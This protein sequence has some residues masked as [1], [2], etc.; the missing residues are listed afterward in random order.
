M[1]YRQIELPDHAIRY[2]VAMLQAERHALAQGNPALIAHEMGW[3]AHY[4]SLTAI[5][6][7][8]PAEFWNE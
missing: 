2:L 4:D 3:M 1:T 7:A 8:I 5:E 6:N